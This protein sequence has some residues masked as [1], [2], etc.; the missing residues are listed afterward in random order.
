LPDYFR[1]GADNPGAGPMSAGGAIGAYRGFPEHA[2]GSA[3]F[4]GSVNDPL[5]LSSTW[6]P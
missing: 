2:T 4:S 5:R 1:S 6:K 3:H